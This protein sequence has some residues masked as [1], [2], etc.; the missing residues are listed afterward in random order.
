MGAGTRRRNR[1]SAGSTQHAPPSETYSAATMFISNCLHVVL[2][3]RWRA[4]RWPANCAACTAELRFAGPGWSK[5]GD[6]FCWPD[7]NTELQYQIGT[8]TFD[9]WVMASLDVAKAACEAHPS[10]AGIHYDTNGPDYLLLS[11][12]GVP[13]GYEPAERTCY[14]FTRPGKRS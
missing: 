13:N 5:L 12:L 2:R 6:G 9:G 3:H 4:W 14:K 10:C 8:Q 1:C 11:K 7:Q